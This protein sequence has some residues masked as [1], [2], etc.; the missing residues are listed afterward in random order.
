MM[1]QKGMVPWRPASGHFYELTPKQ[2]R[3]EDLLQ[4]F[5]EEQM[6]QE[7]ARRL[8]EIKNFEAARQMRDRRRHSIHEAFQIQVKRRRI[9]ELYEVS[10]HASLL[11]SWDTLEKQD[12]ATEA[13]VSEKMRREHLFSMDK[14]SHDYENELTLFESKG[15]DLGADA[16]IDL[17]SESK[18]KDKGKEK[19]K[20]TGKGLKE[21]KLPKKLKSF[22]SSESTQVTCCRRIAQSGE[23][24]ANEHLHP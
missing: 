12:L 6:R 16:S 23:P 7:H 21:E 1:D 4:P 18:N 14:D 5:Y 19:Q 15:Y 2:R 3:E 10:T 8:H 17:S 24:F 22:E 20:D 9:K 13:D 11:A